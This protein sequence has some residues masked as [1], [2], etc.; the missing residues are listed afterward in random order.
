MTSYLVIIKKVTHD[1]L[2]IH[3]IKIWLGGLAHGEVLPLDEASVSGDFTV[4]LHH[5]TQSCWTQWQSYE[6]LKVC[7]FF[8]LSLP[9]PYRWYHYKGNIQATARETCDPICERHCPVK[10]RNVVFDD[11]KFRQLM[12]KRVAEGNGYIC[13]GPFS[14]GL[15]QGPYSPEFFVTIYFVHAQWVTFLYASSE[16]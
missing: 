11:Q 1:V 5:F 2:A 16:L 13:G 6:T 8:N 12:L 9:L 10:N 7:S 4:L 3:S 15:P 14:P